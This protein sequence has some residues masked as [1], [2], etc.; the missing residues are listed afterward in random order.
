MSEIILETRNLVKRFGGI[1]A[2]NK[3]NFLVKR[4]EIVGLIGPNGAGK[5]TLFNC[6]TGTLRPDG[7]SILFEG[8]NIAGLLSHKIAKLGIARTW[9][10]VRPFRKMT[11]LD[12]ITVGALL[13]HNDIEVARE[14]AKESALFLGLPE[15]I[16][17]RR[18]DEITLMQHKLVDMARALA[19]EPKL[20]LIDEVGSGLRPEELS[21]MIETIQRIN[22]EKNITLVV[23]EH[24]MRL[25]MSI[26]KRIVVM[27]EGRIIAD[28]K[29]EEISNDPQV[30]QAYLGTKPV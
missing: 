29:P 15:S 4:G 25:V 6:I 27:H 19:T 5:T 11:V 1:T 24:I 23:V 30:I 10:I 22:R 12:A 28:G 17:E 2:V 26:S 7:G 18:G 16:L 8:R 13:R 9:Q 21:S 3:V 20:L 14:K